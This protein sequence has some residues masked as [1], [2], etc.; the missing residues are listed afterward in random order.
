MHHRKKEHQESIQLC[1]RANNGM[2]HFGSTKCWY[3]HDEENDLNDIED[4]EVMSD[5][6]QKVIAKLFDIVEKFTQRIFHLENNL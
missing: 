2:C 5:E 4:I 3:K 1:E 6:N